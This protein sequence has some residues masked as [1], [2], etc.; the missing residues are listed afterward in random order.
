MLFD[1][2]QN[3]VPREAKSN[4]TRLARSCRGEAV[5]NRVATEQRAFAQ[6]LRPYAT[7]CALSPCCGP[8]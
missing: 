1:I 2:L 8:I 6:L 4:P 7:L 3:C 5:A